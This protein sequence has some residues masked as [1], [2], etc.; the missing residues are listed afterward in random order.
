MLQQTNV[1]DGRQHGKPG[2][3]HNCGEAGHWACKYQKPRKEDDLGSG[4]GGHGGGCG[5]RGGVVETMMDILADAV[6]K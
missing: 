3:C 6:R 2:S 1:S 4:H 5:G